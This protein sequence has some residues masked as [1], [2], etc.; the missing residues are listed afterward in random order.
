MKESTFLDYFNASFKEDNSKGTLGTEL[1][2][3]IFEMEERND[4]MESEETFINNDK[5]NAN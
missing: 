5:Y 2:K 4:R 1:E 3:E